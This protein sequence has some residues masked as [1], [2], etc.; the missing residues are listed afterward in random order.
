M[1]A[2]TDA[3]NRPAHYTQG[4]V[5]CIDAIESATSGIPGDEGFLVG[6]VIKYTW[7]YRGKNGVEDIEK[8]LWYLGRLHALCVRKEEP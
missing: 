5:E 2:K 8:A 3:V 6:Q 7:R 4:K 1:K